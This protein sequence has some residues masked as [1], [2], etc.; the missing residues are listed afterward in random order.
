MSMEKHTPNIAVVGAG[1]V[2][3]YFGGMLAQAGFPVTMIARPTQLESLQTLGIEIIWTEH[4]AT[5]PVQATTDY[6]ALAKADYVFIATKSHAS[7]E[8]AR[9]I[10]P[11]LN[12]QAVVLS[13]QNGLENAYLLKQ[14]IGQ[15]CVSAIVYAAI[16]MSGPN[17]V[18]HNGGGSLIIGDTESAFDRAQLNQ[19]AELLNH[20][21]IPTQVSDHIHVDLWSKF[22]VNCAFNGLSAIGNISYANL[23]QSPGVPN[24]IHAIVD[25]CIQVAR[26]ENVLLDADQINQLIRDVPINWPHQKSSTS[27]DLVH[28]RP[29][30]IDFLNGSIVRKGELHHIPTPS[31]RMIYALIKMRE[32]TQGNFVPKIGEESVQVPA[33]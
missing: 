22:V 15:A 3:C 18:T 12:P 29:T 5:F 7:S 9:A 26:A 27:Q 30:E 6:G 13:L 4:R 1:A 19:I 21:K 17:Q 10:A 24:I 25:E 2:G 28:N 31:N 14:H 20:A 23:V 16:A 11:F 8:T 33:G 32:Y